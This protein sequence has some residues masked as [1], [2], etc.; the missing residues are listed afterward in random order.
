MR[1]YFILNGV[2]S[3]DFGV[4]ISGQGTFSAPQKAYTYYNVPGRNGA[5]LGNEHRLENIEVSYEA[6]IYTDFSNNIAKFRTFLLSLN[7]Y[8]KLID[9][10][11]LDEYRYAVYEGPFEPEVTQMNDAGSFTITFSCKPQR[12][13]VSG[14]TSYYWVAGGAQVM[15]GSELNVYAP[16]LDTSKLSWNYEYHNGQSVYQMNQGINSTYITPITPLSPITLA[17]CTAMSLVIDGTTVYSASLLGHPMT[18]GSINLI[19]GAATISSNIQNLPTS[20][21]STYSTNIYR[22]SSSL[23]IYG[24]SHYSIASLAQLSD[25]SIH[26]AIAYDGSYIYIKDDRFANQTQFSTWLS[27]ASVQIDASASVSFSVTAYTPNYPNGYMTVSG[28]HGSSKETFTMEYSDA[29]LMSNPTEFPSSPLIRAYGN[30]VFVM[31]GVT[32]TITN[33]TTYTD[34]DCDLMDC[35]EGS[36]NR[37]NDVSFS[38]YDFPLLRPGDNTVSISSGITALEIIPRWWRV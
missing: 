4:Y 21:W 11:H 14:D 22:R 30:G 18:K 7:G 27:S 37:N 3:R 10:Y 9:S 6:F 38:T 19:T 28:Q 31:D 17:Q 8:T 24:C 20:S 16:R 15:T 2:D 5:I 34:I 35:Y 23:T 12:Y 33:A 26:Y 29:D 36:T 25:P 1:N 13:L 32:I